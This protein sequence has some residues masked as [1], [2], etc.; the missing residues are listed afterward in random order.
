MISKKERNR[1]R[2]ER[3]RLERER[4]RRFSRTRTGSEVAYRLDT[5]YSQL[6]PDQRRR[7]VNTV[8]RGVRVKNG[9]RERLHNSTQRGRAKIKKRIRNRIGDGFSELLGFKVGKK[10]RKSK[11]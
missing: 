2:K 11:E 1:I 7:I 5:G 4:S 3:K 10:S 6:P 8:D 9:I